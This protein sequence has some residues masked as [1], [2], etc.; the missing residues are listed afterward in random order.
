MRYNKH[1]KLVGNYG[2]ELACKY[3]LKNGYQVINRNIYNS[4]KEI[5]IVAKKENI[6]TFIEVKTR[7]TSKYG[8]A[9]DMMSKQKIKNFKKAIG[10]YLAVKNNE[11]YINIRMDFIAVDINKTNKSAKIKHYKDII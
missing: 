3:L 2:E 9:D 8:T 4:H 10:A 11:I 6:L 7:T 1:N 5:D